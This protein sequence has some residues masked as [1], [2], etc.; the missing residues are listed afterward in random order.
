MKRFSIKLEWRKEIALKGVGDI[1][2]KQAFCQ[3]LTEIIKQ[4][5]YAEGLTEEQH[6]KDPTLWM[7]VFAQPFILS[8]QINVSD[9]MISFFYFCEQIRCCMSLHEKSNGGR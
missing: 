9:I 3:R 2:V 1:G 8:P 4:S 5:R 6:L 7:S